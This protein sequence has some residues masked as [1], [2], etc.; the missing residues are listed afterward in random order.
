MLGVRKGN[1]AINSNTR[2]K[3]LHTYAQHVVLARKIVQ[4]SLVEVKENF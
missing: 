1:A 2:E 3:C 4:N